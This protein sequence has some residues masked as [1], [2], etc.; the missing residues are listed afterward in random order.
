MIR[1]GTDGI[2]FLPILKR[3]IYLERCFNL[4]LGSFMDRLKE[5][6]AIGHIKLVKYTG[7]GVL[8]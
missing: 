7:K 8:A 2:G 3:P 4:Q 6:A 1:K 5:V